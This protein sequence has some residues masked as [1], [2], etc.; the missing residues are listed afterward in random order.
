MAEKEKLLL[1]KEK[2]PMLHCN[3]DTLKPLKTLIREEKKR[4][5]DVWDNPKVPKAKLMQ[6]LATITWTNQV[7]GCYQ[8][9]LKWR[10]EGKLAYVK[11]RM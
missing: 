11:E 10:G 2:D 8:Q 4:I 7:K 1:L 9:A 3:P 6:M 5:T